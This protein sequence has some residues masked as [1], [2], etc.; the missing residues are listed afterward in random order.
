MDIGGS[1]NDN[2][3]GQWHDALL[4]TALGKPEHAG[5]ELLSVLPP[6]VS[7]QLDLKQLDLQPGSFVD[8]ELRQSH[9]DLLFRTTYA[10]D[11]AYVYVLIEHQRTPE[12][13]MAL[14]MLGYQVRIW[15]RHVAENPGATTIP[16][17]V[18][19]VIY[20]GRRRW[21]APVDVAD[22]LDATPE[23]SD[24]LGALVPHARY[25][26]DDLTVVDDD[27]LRARP[28]T[29]GARITLVSLSKAPGDDDATRWL[30]DWL[31]D[32]QVL[33]SDHD[34]MTALLTYYQRV[35][36]TPRERLREFAATIGPEAEE[37]AMTTAEQLEAIGEA[38]GKALGQSEMLTTM[39]TARFG[40]LNEPTRHRIDD[41]TPDQI[42]TW[43]TRLARGTDTLADVFAE[44]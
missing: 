5:S 41:A 10:G 36:G 3:A 8:G 37:I 26:L 32:F 42:T 28:L 9:T 24:A 29:P 44:R 21:A 22:L 30:I 13:L 23:A 16:V 39:L 40:E 4:R 20:Q 27:A 15:R 33:E 34:L 25:V 1:S 6:E 12:P 7:A 11:D 43:A 18:P 31:A 19:V 2:V 35:S 14:R 38:R 17:I